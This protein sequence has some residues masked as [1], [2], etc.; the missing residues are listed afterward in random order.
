MSFKGIQNEA[1]KIQLVKTMN[2]KERKWR[3][4]KQ[5]IAERKKADR[6]EKRKEKQNKVK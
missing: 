5:T 1:K 3:K 6:R 2:K 4:N